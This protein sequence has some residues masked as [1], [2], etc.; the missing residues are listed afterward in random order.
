MIEL[1]GGRTCE[2]REGEIRLI[3]LKYASSVIADCPH[4]VGYRGGV[5]ACAH[6]NSARVV[7]LEG[8]FFNYR[9]L[10]EKT[11]CVIR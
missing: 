5:R 1:P 8:G 11:A 10:L 4:S 2:H 6:G 9:S 3:G 7:D